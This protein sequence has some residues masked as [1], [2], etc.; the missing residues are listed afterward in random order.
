[1]RTSI[2]LRSPW[3]IPAAAAALVTAAIHLDQAPSTWHENAYVGTGFVLL[4]IACLAGAV[5]LTVYD[6]P[7]TWLLIGSTCAAAI[8]GYVFSR[9]IGLPGMAGDIGNWAEP[10]GIAA[11]ASEAFVAAATT[12]TAAASR[13]TVVLKAWLGLPAGQRG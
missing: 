3:R 9:G 8:A 2:R 13:R 10:A 4:A 12:A 1:M 6:A 5:A 11:V 7:V